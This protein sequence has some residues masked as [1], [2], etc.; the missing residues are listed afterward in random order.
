MSACKLSGKQKEAFL[1]LHSLTGNDH[2]S[3]IPRKR[4]QLCWKHVKENS[5]FL[6]GQYVTSDQSLTMLKNVKAPGPDFF[7]MDLVKDAAKFISKSLAMT[8]N[9]SLSK[10]IF[11]SFHFIFIYFHRVNTFSNYGYLLFY[12]VPCFK[13]LTYLIT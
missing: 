5:I 7:P 10:G 6:D 12:N 13:T 4:K 2:F 11:I 1:G 8:F 9:A 3:S